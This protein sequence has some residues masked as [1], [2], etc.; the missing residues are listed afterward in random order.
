M[1]GP[2]GALL[3]TRQ[4]GSSDD[5]YAPAVAVDGAGNAY[6]AG[7]TAGSLPGCPTATHRSLR[8]L[9]WR[10]CRALAR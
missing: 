1:Y 7:T 9:L 5:D 8:R 4:F 6:G 3:W 2:D 10:A